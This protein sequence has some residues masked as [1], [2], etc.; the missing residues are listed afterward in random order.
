MN[1]PEIIAVVKDVFLAIAGATTATVAVIGLNNWNRE[2]RGKATF[3]VARGLAKAT[4]KL[5]DELMT[6]RS[7]LIRGTEFPDEYNLAGARKTPEQE[8]QAYAHMYSNRWGPVWSALQEFDTHT[9]EAEALWGSVI[10][11]K[12]DEL[13]KG[14]R[15]LNIAIEAVVANAASGGED[16]SADR[17]FGRKMRSTVAAPPGDAKNELTRKLEA[18]I[19]G[20]EDELRPHL[21]R[22]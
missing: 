15:E 7:P 21:K 18:A 5:R 11:T 8:A 4:Y 12:T 22:S 1:V 6:C 16:F 10:R 9:L 2:L 3:D 19:R 14:V 13:R 20:I 17:E